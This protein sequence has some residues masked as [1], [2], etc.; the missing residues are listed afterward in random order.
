MSGTAVA[1]EPSRKLSEGVVLN[2]VANET[3]LTT[4]AADTPIDKTFPIIAAD[5]GIIIRNFLSADLLKRLQTELRPFV[6]GHEP[7][8]RETGQIWQLFHG[9]KTKRFCG[10]AAKSAAFVELLL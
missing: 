9:P 8:S 10:L 1:I 7:G 2:T 5:G 6:D 3:A 4:V